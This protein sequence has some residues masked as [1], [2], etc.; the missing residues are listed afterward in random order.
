MSYECIYQNNIFYIGSGVTSVPFN[1]INYISPTNTILHGTIKAVYTFSL[2]G[3]FQE[4]NTTTAFVS[5]NEYPCNNYHQLRY[6]NSNNTKGNRGEIEYYLK[7]ETAQLC[8]GGKFTFIRCDTNCST[9][10]QSTECSTCLTGYAFTFDAPNK[11]TNIT[12][13]YK[14][15]QVYYKCHSTCATCAKGFE[16]DKHNCETCKSNFPFYK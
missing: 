5:G 6:L 2:E 11:C 15:G 13:Y 16:G 12:G 4:N 10:D 8:D 14:D 1:P 7:N 9:C 3:T